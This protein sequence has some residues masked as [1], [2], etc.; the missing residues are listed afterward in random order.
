M[1]QMTDQNTRVGNRYAPTVNYNAAVK[2]PIPI[3]RE[4][5]K[6]NPNVNIDVSGIADSLLK[7]ASDKA[8]K[9]Q[10]AGYNK[11][12]LAV[13]DIVQGQRQGRYNYEQ[14]ETRIRS[15]TDQ[16][17]ASGY[18]ALELAKRRDKYDGGLY[19]LSQDQQKIIADHETKRQTAEME[20]FRAKNDYAK[21]WS[22]SRVKMYIDRSNQIQ[23]TVDYYNLA[24]NNPGLADEDRERLTAERDEAFES[25]GIMNMHRLIQNRLNSGEEISQEFFT[26]L[27]NL[28]VSQG[29]A[30]GMDYREATLNK[31]AMMR[32]MDVGTLMQNKYKDVVDNT[33]AMKKIMNYLDAGTQR[34]IRSIPEGSVMYNIPHEVIPYLK[35]GNE[36]FLTQLTNKIYNTDTIN[37]QRYLLGQPIDKSI[38]KGAIQASATVLRHNITDSN[39]PLSL[40]SRQAVVF[41]QDSV[42]YNGELKSLTPDQAAVA[43]RNADDMLAILKDPTLSTRMQQAEPDLKQRYESNVQAIEGVKAYADAMKED[44][45]AIDNLNTLLGSFQADRLRY[46]PKTGDLVMTE[47]DAFNWK[48]L[49]TYLPALG[50]IF[51]NDETLAEVDKFNKDFAK[52]S[53]TAKQA[54]INNLSNGAVKPLGDTEK[55]VNRDDQNIFSKAW[56]SVQRAPTKAFKEAEALMKGADKL[57]QSIRDVERSGATTEPGKLER[58]KQA[59]EAARAKAQELTGS[60][61]VSGSVSIAGAAMRPAEDSDGQVRGMQQSDIEELEMEREL[62]EA[63]MDRLNAADNFDQERYQKLSNRL[64][65]IGRLLESE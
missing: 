40:L 20:D 1:V 35:Q 32:A 10:E 31:D 16:Y 18:D 48:D 52:L 54:L 42:D 15:L 65:R 57:E 3:P 25:L 43:S 59:V 14:A 41:S 33:E 26:D 39:Y 24:L 6:V 23:D 51:S 46:D 21:G 61:K 28:A 27:G 50:R 7:A 19:K 2:S 5:P 38:D 22:D 4:F 8:A 36:N 64:A 13:D 45:S 11:Y 58:D 34:A 17:M 12:A 47:T 53:P 56:G 62:I 44:P 49:D 60:A 37:N 55:T 29:V 63:E 9:E 30:S